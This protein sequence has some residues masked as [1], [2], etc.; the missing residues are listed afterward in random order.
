MPHVG[1]RRRGYVP[2]VDGG[3]HELVDG[4]GA[5]RRQARRGPFN[6]RPGP[7]EAALGRDDDPLGEVSQHGIAGPLEAAPR[8]AAGG[9]PGLLPDH[10]AP[11]QQPQAVLE[12][13]DHVGGQGAV[14]APSQVGDV[15]RDAPAG[16]QF[17]D[18][19]GEHV[20]QHLEIVDVAGGD[21]AVPHRLLVLLAGVVGRRGHHQRDRVVGHIAAGVHVAG[22]AH[23]QAVGAGVG[24]DLVGVADLRR[25]EPLVERRGVVGLA[26]AH[27]EAGRGRAPPTPARPAHGP[28]G[29]CREPSR[30]G[31]S[32][33][34]SEPYCRDPFCEQ[35]CRPQRLNCSQKITKGLR[36]WNRRARPRPTGPPLPG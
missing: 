23:P 17:A 7:V 26:A 35:I 14:R 22:V 4:G 29:R 1:G 31:V 11:Q 27:P 20:L 24:P 32:T 3:L 9:A 5:V 34:T 33:R 13:G 12:Y 21:V 6:G 8:T 10:L 25:R 36:R 18:A 19:F 28:S 15:H 16:L 30:P 2:D